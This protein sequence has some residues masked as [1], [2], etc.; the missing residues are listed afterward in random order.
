[1]I[2]LLRNPH[3]MDRVPN[4]FLSLAQYNLICLKVVLN[5]F[6]LIFLLHLIRLNI[7]LNGEIY[8]WEEDVYYIENFLISSCSLK[9][10]VNKTYLLICIITILCFCTFY[11]AKIYKQRK[12][13]KID[14]ISDVVQTMPICHT[15]VLGRFHCKYTYGWKT[16]SQNAM[17]LPDITAIV[18]ADT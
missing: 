1:M 15:V 5:C 10:S 17:V 7:S 16:E 9:H 4:V 18:I 8:V 14:L 3:Y 12:L 13:L 2:F 6:P 11:I